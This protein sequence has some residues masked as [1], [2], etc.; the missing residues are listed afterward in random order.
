MLPQVLGLM[1]VWEECQF[2]TSFPVDVKWP[3]GTADIAAPA[4][5]WRWEMVQQL[6]RL[7][8]LKQSQLSRWQ[9]MSAQKERDQMEEE[10]YTMNWP[11]QGV[12]FQVENNEIDSKWGGGGRGG[13]W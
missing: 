8:S 5:A 13:R 10:I 9:E 6:Y 2:S 7:L 11:Y 4:K 3:R 12:C 1:A